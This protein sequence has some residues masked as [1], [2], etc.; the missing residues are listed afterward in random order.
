MSFCLRKVH[1]K[2]RPRV[3]KQI[4]ITMVVLSVILLV[5]SLLT[6]GDADYGKWFPFFLVGGAAL[7]WLGFKK[8]RWA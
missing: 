8:I 3:D 4:G 1:L 6:I 5:S 2:E 7:G